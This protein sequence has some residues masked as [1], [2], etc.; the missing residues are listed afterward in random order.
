M[1]V[2]QDN[3]IRIAAVTENDIAHVFEVY[4]QC[5]DFLAMGP[6]PTASEKMV[7][8]DFAHS[9]KENGLYCGVFDANAKMLG[10]VD[11]IPRA[12]DDDGEEAFISLIMIAK[13]HRDQGLGTA[14]IK[15]VEK[16][17]GKY[18]QNKAILS[19]V[20]TNNG[21][22]IKFWETL[23]YRIT[24]E[25]EARPDGTIVYNLRKDL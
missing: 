16:Y 22:A 14:V 3:V 15:A 2:Y 24:G 12:F 19:A 13:P 1:M 7:R 21:K 11:F 6:E 17:I 9:K 20:Q 4:Q 25:P 10:I 5:E 18:R 23:G 8:D